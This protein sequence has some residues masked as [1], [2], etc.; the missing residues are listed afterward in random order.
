MQN[1]Y[2]RLVLL[3]NLKG[4]PSRKNQRTFK[5]AR[6]TVWFYRVVNDYVMSAHTKYINTTEMYTDSSFFSTV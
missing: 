1:F 3:S 6:N 2:R 4:L 5:L